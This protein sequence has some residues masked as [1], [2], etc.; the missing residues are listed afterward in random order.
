MAEL[1]K[2]SFSSNGQHSAILIRALSV[3]LRQSLMGKQ[4]RENVRIIG[5]HSA[6]LI[7]A[8]SVI[9]RQSLME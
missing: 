4:C 5:Q 9:L 8:L 6:I 7:T 3:I 1:Y 2:Q